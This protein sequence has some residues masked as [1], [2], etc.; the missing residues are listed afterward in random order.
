MLAGRV[1]G[2]GVES[3]EVP[4]EWLAHVLAVVGLVALAG[5]LARAQFFLRGGNMHHGPLC[6]QFA[7]HVNALA[8]LRVVGLGLPRRRFG[9]DVLRA[10]DGL[11]GYLLL[12]AGPGPSEVLFFLFHLPHVLI[13]QLADPEGF[14][15]VLRR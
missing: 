13:D 15:G 9:G 12:V 1:A 3:P 6:L 4:A 7:F 2:A 14:D 11:Q 8:L 5:G 10:V